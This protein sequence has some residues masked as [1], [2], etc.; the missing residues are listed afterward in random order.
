MVG[1]AGKKRDL[2]VRTMRDGVSPD[3]EPE[4]PRAGEAANPVVKGGVHDGRVL[5]AQVWWSLRGPGGT[6]CHFSAPL[7]IAVCGQ[8]LQTH[9]FAD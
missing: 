8:T 2:H 9:N 5:K 3:E 7:D 1:R 6:G 4:R